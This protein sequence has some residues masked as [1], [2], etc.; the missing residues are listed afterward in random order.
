VWHLAKSILAQNQSARI[1]RAFF[2]SCSPGSWWSGT[3]RRKNN[4]ARPGRNSHGLNKGFKDRG[5]EDHFAYKLVTD[6]EVFKIREAYK[7]EPS[8]KNL[9]M[10][11]NR[12]MATIR[13]IVFNRGRFETFKLEGLKKA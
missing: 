12:P 4:M 8:I 7:Q 13:D 10:Q 11:F 5:V 9:A 1:S 2:I 3:R 6:E